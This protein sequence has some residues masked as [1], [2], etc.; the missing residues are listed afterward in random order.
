MNYFNLND[1][2]IIITGGAGML[3]EKHVEAIIVA[4]GKPIVLDHSQK[5]LETLKQKIE[6]KFSYNLLYFK[7]D[8]TNELQ[9]KKILAKIKDLKIYI[10]GIIN[11]AAINPTSENLKNFE[12]RVEKFT[13]EN[14]Y[15]FLDV[16]LTGTFLILKHFGS[17]MASSN[18]GGVIINVS[19]D[20]GI[21]APDQR[22][23][24]HG[25][26][27]KEY[28]EVKPITYSV[29]K[30]GMIGFTKYISTYWSGKNIRCNAICPGGI[31]T[32]DMNKNFIK[33]INELIPLGRMA[34]PDEYQGTIIWMLSEASSYLNGAII[35]VDGGRS[36]W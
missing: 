24:N 11:N 3:G 18:K 14:W 20:L 6:K 10:N 8:I 28:T 15:K 17:Y 1:K 2:N 4:G 26:K 32:K 30:A 12:S 35:T 27:N 5:K 36:V 13:L 23:Y 16:E 9:V 34:K 29:S 19:S 21:I 7:V 22:L 25:K 31:Y 33:K